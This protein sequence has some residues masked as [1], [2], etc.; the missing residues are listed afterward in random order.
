MLPALDQQKR[1]HIY[2]GLYFFLISDGGGLVNLLH[3]SLSRVAEGLSLESQ[4][5]KCAEIFGIP[6]RIV[7]RAQYVTSV[8]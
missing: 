5:A 7:K 4:A 6:S 1:S 8:L 3:I 2:I